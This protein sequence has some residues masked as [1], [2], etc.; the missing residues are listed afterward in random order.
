[1]GRQADYKEHLYEQ[2][3]RIGK[4]LGHPIRLEIL[5]LLAQGEHSVETLCEKIGAPLANVSQHLQRLR[6]AKLVQVRRQGTYIF[7]R[8]ADE[9]VSLA[10]QSIKKLA[11]QRYYELDRLMQD[12]QAKEVEVISV[13]ELLARLHDKD[14]L[15]L[16]AR[17]ADE[18]QAGHLPEALSL[19]INVLEDRLAHLP[20]DR[21][22]VAYCRNEYCLLSDELA[23]ALKQRGYQVKRL[24]QGVAE[25][26]NQ[27]HPLSSSDSG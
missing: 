20:Q 26:K 25:W 14:I 27:G 18:Y 23:L 10:W 13:E 16:D 4:V 5:D 1:M 21:E 9:E 15:L 12:Y 8:L 24:A 11:Q 17:P 2:F 3:A 6:G 22:F 7:Y 19:P